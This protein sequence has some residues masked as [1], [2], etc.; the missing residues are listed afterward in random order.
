MWLCSIVILSDWINTCRFRLLNRYDN[1]FR[2]VFNYA[3]CSDLKDIFYPFLFLSTIRFIIHFVWQ[4]KPYQTKV[5]QFELATHP[6]L[7]QFFSFLVHSFHIIIYLF[8][9]YLGFWFILSILA[10]GL[11]LFYTLH[12]FILSSALI[13]LHLNFVSVNAFLS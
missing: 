8:R 2:R 6:L 3:F 1:S 7:I 10:R 12:W 13:F 5:S 4:N 9:Q 11:Y